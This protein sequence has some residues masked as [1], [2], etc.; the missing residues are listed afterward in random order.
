MMIIVTNTLI[1]YVG[2][3]THLIKKIFYLGNFYEV[4]VNQ[5]LSL[6]QESFI[7]INNEMPEDIYGNPKKT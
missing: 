6:F 5:Y 2:K 3:S 7:K 4:K 1:V